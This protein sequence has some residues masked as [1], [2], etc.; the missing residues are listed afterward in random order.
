MGICTFERDLA[1]Y[2][3]R[4]DADDRYME[5][6]EAK[7]NEIAEE[8]REQM[9]NAN[10]D[11]QNI[12]FDVD[13]LPDEIWDMYEDGVQPTKEQIDTFI[14]ETAAGSIEAIAESELGE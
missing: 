1:N 3:A 5:A 13:F 2:M 14:D 4:V 10:G 11:I 12:D 8:L 7:A 6:V 9:M